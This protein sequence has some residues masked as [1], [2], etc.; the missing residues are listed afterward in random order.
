MAAKVAEKLGYANVSREV[1]LGASAR[2]NIPKSELERAIHDPPSILERFTFG[3]E[4]FIAYIASALLDRFVQGNVIYH[5]LAGHFFV[6]EVSHVL[7]VRIIADMEARIQMKMAQNG[8]N[9]SHALNKLQRDDDARRQ[10]GLKLYGL[11]TWDPRLYDMVLHIRKLTVDD[12]ADMICRAAGLK[13]FAPTPES[14][15][16]IDNLALAARVKAEIVD[17]YP[18]SEVSASSGVVDVRIG[19]SQQM[20]TRIRDEINCLPEKI[21]GI[22]DI[23]LH[24]IPATLFR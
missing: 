9:R 1:I 11:D 18:T 6:R 24:L 5:G 10:W 2:F 15:Q 16:K 13:Q 14:L 17:R 21:P 12:V 4:R 8:M 3:R 22:K 19:A 20:E 23:R 7:K